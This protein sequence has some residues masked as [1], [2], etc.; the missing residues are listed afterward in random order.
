MLTVSAAAGSLAL[1]TH[2]GTITITASGAVNSAVVVPVVFRIGPTITGPYTISTIAGV[3]A[4]AEGGAAN[5]Q[6]MSPPQSVALD[7]TGNLYL[8]V[9]D[10]NKV[11]KMTPAGI[12]TTFAGTGQPGP[13]G[14]GGPAPSAQLN[15]PGGV[16][17][18]GNGDVYIADWVNNRIR[19]VS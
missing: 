11:Y 16:A 10:R 1:G 15:S 9:P 8:A 5:A 17:V 4:I 19:K 14:D 3:N 7:T 6:P 13:A 18:D 12:L 2:T